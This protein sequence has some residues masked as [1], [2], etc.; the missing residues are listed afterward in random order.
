MLFIPRKYKFKKHQKG[1]A[2]NLI[3]SNL[4]FVKLKTGN[5]GLK[6]LSH[7]RVTSKQ[8]LTLKQILK[9]ILKKK[10]KILLKIFPNTPITQ[11]AIG[12][13]MGKGKGNVSH[14]VFRLKPGFLICEIA[15]NNIPLALKALKLCRYRT[16]MFTKSV[17]F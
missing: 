16:S 13:R 7:C 3:K 4:N 14:W 10:G 8:I 6:A 17:Y 1:R 9:K 5:I 15:T 2:F 11:K 12:V